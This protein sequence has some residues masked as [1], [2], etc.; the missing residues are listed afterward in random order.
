[1]NSHDGFGTRLVVEPSALGLVSEGEVRS[2]DAD[3]ERGIV[4]PD[5]ARKLEF[6]DPT[7]VVE[8]GLRQRAYRI[9]DLLAAVRD[10]AYPD[11]SVVQRERLLRVLA[12]VRKDDDAVPDS[13]RPG[14]FADDLVE[15]RS[16]FRDLGPVLDK[17]TR[18]HLT[19]R[20][21]RLWQGRQ[22]VTVMRDDSNAE[23]RPGQQDPRG[24]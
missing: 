19:H 2:L 5:L 3:L 23:E 10:G 9:L 6:L 8:G 11:L 7:D 1:M 4:P 15:A 17:F 24:R 16:A 22:P 14:G 12:Y 18:W 20:V 13:R 21:P